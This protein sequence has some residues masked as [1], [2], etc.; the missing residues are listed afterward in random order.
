[1]VSILENK[2]EILG[3]LKGINRN[4]MEKLITYLEKSD[5]FTAPAAASHHSNF[6]GGLAEHSLNVYRL[7]KEKNE[8][9]KLGYSE[10]TIILT[11]LLHDLCKI[12]VYKKGYKLRKNTNDQWEAYGTYTFEEN[13]PVG[14][15]EK[16]VM[17]A[18]NFINLSKDEILMIRWHMGAFVPQGEERDLYAAMNKCKGVAAIHMADMESTHFLETSNEIEEIVSMEFYNKWKNSQS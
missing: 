12:G 16:S 9:Y 17:I 13:F 8:K 3:L 2:K 4:G 7:L 10:E 5:F 11:S 15:G 1:M 14:H 6:E 18:M